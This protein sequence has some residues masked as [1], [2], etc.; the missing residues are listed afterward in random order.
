MRKIFVTI[1][2]TLILTACAT[3]TSTK[4]QMSGESLDALGQLFN[5]VSVNVTRDCIANIHTKKTCADFTVMSDK[6]KLAFPPARSLWNTA[7]K[8][9]DEGLGKAAE[10]ALQKL[11]ADLAP[12]AKLIGGAK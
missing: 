8:Y 4:I 12:F 5:R 1:L 9:E 10:S 11:T 3:A 7:V 2:T 6:F